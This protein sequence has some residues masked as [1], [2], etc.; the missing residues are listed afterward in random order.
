MGNAEE[1][2]RIERTLG[3]IAGELHS[4]G[5]RFGPERGVGLGGVSFAKREISSESLNLAR[6][7]KEAFDPKGIMNPQ[8]QTI[9]NRK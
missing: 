7:V 6:R 1:I 3:K 8:M 5:G 9:D 4:L 2:D